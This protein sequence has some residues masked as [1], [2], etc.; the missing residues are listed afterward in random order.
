MFGRDEVGDFDGLVEIAHLD[1]RGACG[2]GLADDLHPLHAGSRR[3][4]D[5]RTR[6]RNALSGLTRMAAHPR[7]ARPART[8]PW[9]S[10][11]DRT[12]VT[13]HQYFRWAGDHV[14]PHRAEYHALGG[15]DIDIAGPNDLVDAR[16]AVR[17]IRERRHRLRTADAEDT[18]D[19]G[20]SGGGQHQFIDF[21]IG[22]GTTMISSGTPATL[23]GMA[24]INT[25]DGYAALPP[26]TYKPTRSKGVT[27][28]PSTVPSAS[29]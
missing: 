12:A 9:Q 20:N 21:S 15:G 2:Q 27:C 17:S 22:V 23:A 6:S 1:E 8:Y 14:D 16:H 26:G 29:V 19:T 4:M 10:S 11:R 5:S 13:D 18:V 25:E 24:F 3:A 28:C 7:R